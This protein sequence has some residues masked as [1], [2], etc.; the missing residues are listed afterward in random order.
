MQA[1][2]KYHG[3]ITVCNEPLTKYV[4]L[5]VSHAPGMPGTFSPP[6]RVYNTDMHT[7]RTVSFEVGG[8]ETV[9][10]ILLACATHNCTY[11]LR[12]PWSRW[13]ELKFY[14]QIT[15]AA[16]KLSRFHLPDQDTMEINNTALH[17]SCVYWLEGNESKKCAAS[18]TT[19]DFLWITYS[20]NQ[21]DF[22]RFKWKLNIG[23]PYNFDLVILAI[24]YWHLYCVNTWTFGLWFICVRNACYN[25]SHSFIQAV[26]NVI[27]HEVI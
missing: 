13:W 7:T 17:I 1:L 5:L 10:G 12:G 22:S 9:P 26:P 21:N 2:Q 24:F 4:K 3:K 23:E 8:G 14:I 6:P 16:C 27:T 20:L 11:L 19:F 15:R 25:H 18:A